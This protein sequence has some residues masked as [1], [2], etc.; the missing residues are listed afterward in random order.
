MTPSSPA[1]R[2]QVYTH[3]YTCK[4]IYIHL[5]GDQGYLYTHINIHTHTYTYIHTHT[6]TYTHIH[7]YMYMYI[8]HT[9][10]WDQGVTTRRGIRGKGFGL[11]S[12]KA[13][14][15][16]QGKINM[17]FVSRGRRLLQSEPGFLLGPRLRGGGGGT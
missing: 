3:T 1:I 13:A 16:G 11:P 4:Y 17:E 2:V 15:T 10:I 5:S 7:M 14:L 12:D 6:H 8:I 9:F